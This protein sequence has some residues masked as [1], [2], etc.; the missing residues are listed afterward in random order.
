MT[1]RAFTDKY[2][3]SHTAVRPCRHFNFPR[4]FSPEFHIFRT[5]K[6]RFSSQLTVRTHSHM[7][8]MQFSTINSHKI[9]RNLPES[10][11]AFVGLLSASIIFRVCQTAFY[12]NFQARSPQPQHSTNKKKIHTTRLKLSNWRFLNSQSNGIHW[13][14]LRISDRRIRFFVVNLPFREPTTFFNPST[15][16]LNEL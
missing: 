15:V 3:N 16:E 7:K 1:S 14:F 4:M 11:A 10:D 2:Y 6:C 13:I 5:T 9:C 8:T 12:R